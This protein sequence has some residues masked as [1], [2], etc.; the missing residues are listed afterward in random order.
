MPVDEPQR[1]AAETRSR[2][3]LQDPERRPD[4]RKSHILTGTENMAY[5]TCKWCRAEIKNTYWKYLKHTTGCNRMRR[6]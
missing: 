1:I 2:E 5:Y 6:N 3:E 4:P